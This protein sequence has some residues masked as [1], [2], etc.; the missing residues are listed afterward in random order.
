SAD[1]GKLEF[2]EHHVVLC[3]LSKVNSSKLEALVSR[4]HCLS[5]HA[6][7]QPNI[8]QRYSEYALACFERIQAILQ[9][10]PQGKVLVQIVVADHQEQAVLAGLSG[11]LKTAALENPQFI[12]QL[13][14]APALTTAEE[15]AKWLQ[16]EQPRPLDTLIR[17]RSEERRVGKECK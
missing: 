15:L 11:L 16:A 4:S 9:S 7:Q 17:Y 5:L 14:L 10:K 2:A 8:A 12:G 13:I 6:G 3:E 1:A